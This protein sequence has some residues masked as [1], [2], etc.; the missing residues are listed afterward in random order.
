M[1]DFPAAHPYISAPEILSPSSLTRLLWFTIV[2]RK[3]CQIIQRAAQTEFFRVY[4]FSPRAPHRSSRGAMFFYQRWQIRQGKQIPSQCPHARWLRAA[5]SSV[6]SV[7]F[8]GVGLPKDLEQPNHSFDRTSI[9]RERSDLASYEDVS[10]S[11][12]CQR[13]WL[14]LQSYCILIYHTEHEVSVSY[15]YFHEAKNNPIPLYYPRSP[16][17][18]MK[19][20]FG[21]KKGFPECRN[22]ARKWF[23]ALTDVLREAAF[24]NAPTMP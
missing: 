5:I 11:P 21:P 16:M 7:Q 13:R 18:D 19:L 17:C 23:K 12:L 8:V 1:H 2:S 9:S 4:L 14:H 20:L 22:I 6:L 24:G 15:P 10:D 3:G